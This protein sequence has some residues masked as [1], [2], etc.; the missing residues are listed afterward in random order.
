MTNN[1]TKWIQRAA[2]LALV[3]CS[4]FAMAAPRVIQVTADEDGKF[5]MAGQK[6]KPVMTLKPG[7]V[8]K[9]RITSN[10]GT[11]WEKDGA[12]H[13]FTINALKDQ[14]WDLRLKSGTQEFTLA[15]PSEPGE[16]MVE[17]MVRCGKTHDDMKMKLVVAP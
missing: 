4:L 3:L 9:L 2:M 11:D 10:K 12:V 8:I 17:C 5:K 1:P 13:S 6:G 15:A 16:Y 14:G 7:E